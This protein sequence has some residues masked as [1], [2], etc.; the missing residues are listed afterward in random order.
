MEIC[1]LDYSILVYEICTDISTLVV[2]RDYDFIKN[3][4]DIIIKKY[5]RYVVPLHIFNN[6]KYKFFEENILEFFKDKKFDEF[7]KLLV[8]YESRIF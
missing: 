3:K 8:K 1:K 2:T 5:I 7:F 6:I 4:L